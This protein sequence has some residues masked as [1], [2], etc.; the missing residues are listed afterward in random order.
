MDYCCTDHHMTVDPLRVDQEFLETYPRWL[1]KPLEPFQGSPMEKLT[2]LAALSGWR[3]RE[4]KLSPASDDNVHISFLDW[5]APVLTD[6]SY[7]ELVGEDGKLFRL[8]FRGSTRSFPRS[9]GPSKIGHLQPSGPEDYSRGF[10]HLSDA[11][12]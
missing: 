12:R 10:A 1:G 11:G 8:Y 4:M 2:L 9:G 5:V 6:S 7:V 3:I